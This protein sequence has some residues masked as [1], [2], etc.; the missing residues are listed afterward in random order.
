[1]IYG[2]CSLNVSHHHHHPHH[3]LSVYYPGRIL[4]FQPKL[5]V[6]FPNTLSRTFFSQLIFPPLLSILILPVLECCWNKHANLASVCLKTFLPTSTKFNVTFCPGLQG[7]HRQ[8][9][10]L[11]P[12]PPSYQSDFPLLNMSPESFA[13]C[14][15]NAVLWGLFNNH[16]F[17]QSH[18]SI[19]YSIYHG[20]PTHPS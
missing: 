5:I 10:S 1:M 16:P 14:S 20:N 19:T 18:L 12:S 8:Q 4:F 17:T 11:P 9:A 3:H 6:L 15:V 7:F 2:K 13:H